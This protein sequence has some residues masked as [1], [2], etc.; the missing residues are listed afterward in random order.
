MRAQVLAEL[1]RAGAPPAFSSYEEWEAFV[2]RYVALGLADGYT[3]F[4]WD[5]RPHPS[6]GTLEIRM[7][8]QPTSIELTIA[9]AALLQALCVALADRP[10]R[11]GAAARGDY[12]QNRW[13][14]LHDGPRAR[15]VH[16]FRD[17]VVPASELGRELLAL[18][19]EPAREL[20]T[21][22]LLGALG[23]NTCEADHQLALGRARGLRAVCAD[24]VER[25][26]G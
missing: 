26:V 24:L 17:E 8:D 18:V 22:E 16:P 9:F 19:A 3:R 11:G 15:L 7:L 6:F 4:W 20:G 25:T 21:L 12:A 10:A 2:E 13:A 14:A 5:I 1:P 23:P